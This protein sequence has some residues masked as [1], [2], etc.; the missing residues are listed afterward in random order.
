MTASRVLAA[1]GAVATLGVIVLFTSCGTVPQSEVGFQVGGGPFDGS[2]L[3]VKSDMLQPGR[4][5]LGPLDTVWTFPANRTLRFQDFELEVTTVDGK[6]AALQGQVA[7][8]FVGEKDPDLARNFAEGLGSRK[9]GGERPGESDE[10]WTNLLDQLFLPEIR[11]TLK[12]QIGRV[13]CADFEPACR[14]IDPRENVPEAD[15][16]RVYEAVSEL[17]QQRVDRKLGA[18]YLQELRVRVNRIALP[19]EVQTNIDRV[20]AEQAKTKS[21]EQ[22]AITAEAEAEAITIKARALEANPELVAIEVAK[23]CEGGERCT[24]VVDGTGGVRPAVN[25]GGGGR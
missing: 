21:A 5:V 10:G 22:A 20:T 23:A 12:E 6:K 1:L 9:Y 19:A 2:R 3:K 17:L 25:V 18:P 4:H 14:A 13:Y 7:F 16:E 8:R 24:I 15:P 11:A